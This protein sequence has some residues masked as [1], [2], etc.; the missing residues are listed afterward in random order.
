MSSELDRSIII[1]SIF[2][3]R[4]P[5]TSHLHTTRRRR[6]R[7]EICHTKSRTRNSQNYSQMPITTSCVFMAFSSH[8]N[9][10]PICYLT[11]FGRN[12]L[13]CQESLRPVISWPKFGNIEK[14]IVCTI[15]A[16]EQVV[17]LSWKWREDSTR[18]FALCPS[19]IS[20]VGSSC[21]L[22]VNKFHT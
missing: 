1:H 7:A 14:G 8:G 5:A 2:H 10:L 19:K 20:I 6:A 4:S 21:C 12:H 18:Q 15:S 9:M 13:K 22:S 3:R 16:T 17:S 11:C